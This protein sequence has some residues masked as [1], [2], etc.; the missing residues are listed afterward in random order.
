MRVHH[1]PSG[2]VNYKGHVLN[3]E[4]DVSDVV[5]QLPCFAEGLTMG[6]CSKTGAKTPKGYK[7]FR[8]W[9][10]NVYQWLVWLS[11]NNSHYRD[12]VIDHEALA[13][14]PDDACVA[15]EI[16]VL[17]SDVENV[18]ASTGSAPGEE[19]GQNQQAKGP[20]QGGATGYVNEELEGFPESY[21][22]APLQRNEIQTQKLTD[23]LLNFGSQKDEDQAKEAGEPD[24][25]AE[26]EQT[27]SGPAAG[28]ENDMEHADQATLGTE[29]NPIS[30]P[31]T[32]LRFE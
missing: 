20:D 12:I 23:I 7:D 24:K 18:T 3:V 29:D 21:N 31:S 11:M 16:S 10:K 9:R 25:E 26:E 15:H 4:Q 13:T 14:L 5:S 22:A 28:E 27:G 30:W 8:V 1:M 2:N 17:E 6:H 32:G 19:D